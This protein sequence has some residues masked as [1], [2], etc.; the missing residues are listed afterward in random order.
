MRQISKNFYGL[1]FLIF[2]AATACER[3]DTIKSPDSA[4]G[5]S[6]GNPN[7]SNGNAS[8]TTLPGPYNQSTVP[9]TTVSTT[10]V[11]S[12]VTT[13]TVASTTTLPSNASNFMNVDYN[14]PTNVAGNSTNNAALIRISSVVVGQNDATSVVLMINGTGLNEAVGISVTS[15]C[16]LPQSAWYQNTNPIVIIARFAPSAVVAKTGCKIQLMANDQST[17]ALVPFS[18]PTPG[19]TGTGAISIASFTVKENDTQAVVVEF[20]GTNVTKATS[21]IMGGAGCVDAYDVYADADGV[22]LDFVFNPGDV[23]GKNCTLTLRNSS[24]DSNVFPFRVP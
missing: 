18:V 13:T 11:P 15:P 4:Q 19:P 1:F 23:N 7:N 8:E 21:D 24:G 17:T 2:L 10:T 16:G 20:K 6:T 22:G 3:L 12:N 9:T 14:A 5:S